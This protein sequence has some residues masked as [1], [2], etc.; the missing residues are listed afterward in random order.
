MG[1]SVI[2][3]TGLTALV[4]DCIKRRWHQK[5]SFPITVP[6]LFLSPLKVGMD[7]VGPLHLMNEVFG[8]RET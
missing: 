5:G 4:D 8:R 3:A 6:N 2:V 7:Y 1:H